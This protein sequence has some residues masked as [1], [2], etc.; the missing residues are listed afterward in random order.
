MH[1]PSDN[2]T[3]SKSVCL[4]LN[5]PIL[6]RFF[7]GTILIKVVLPGAV[8]RGREICG[9]LFWG[10]LWVAGMAGRCSLN[11]G[12]NGLGDLTDF[13]GKWSCWAEVM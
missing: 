11:H 3:L 4:N 13:F 9:Y 1:P 12:L 6:K 5:R 7:T 10:G 2:N 8:L